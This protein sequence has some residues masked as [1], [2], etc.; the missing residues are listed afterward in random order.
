MEALPVSEDK[1]ADNK[2]KVDAGTQPYGIE[3]NYRNIAV[4]LPLA[5]GEE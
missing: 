3:N 2:R 4:A 1:N 5:E